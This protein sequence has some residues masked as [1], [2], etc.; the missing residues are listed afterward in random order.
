MLRDQKETADAIVIASI[1]KLRVRQPKQR[2]YRTLSIAKELRNQGKLFEWFSKNSIV[3]HVPTECPSQLKKT[4]YIAGSLTCY[5]VRVDLWKLVNNG[6]FYQF[7]IIENSGRSLL[8]RLVEMD[9]IPIDYL[10]QV[11]N[12]HSKLNEL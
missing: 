9:I 10:P 12:Y 5:K 7:D 3:I 2:L 6:D 1:S 4:V 8:F 11:S